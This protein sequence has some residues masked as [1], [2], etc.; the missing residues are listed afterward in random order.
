MPKLSSIKVSLKL[1]YIGGIEGT[2]EPDETEQRAA[3]EMY[4]ELITRISVVELKPGEGLL[5]EALSSLYSLFNTTR[6]ILRQ[7]GPSVARPKGESDLSFG[8]LAVA[9]L[10][11]VLRPV[12]AK[13]HPLLL[14]YE[15][16]IP[17]AISVTEREDKWEGKESLRQDL[18][19][20]RIILLEYANLLAEVAQVPSLIVSTDNI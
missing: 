20:I 9:I 10:N 7:Y 15:S 16:S 18:N 4:I 14:D 11:T 5:R 2:W 3:W 6:N 17:A 8:F 19:N 1:P 13:W 12:L